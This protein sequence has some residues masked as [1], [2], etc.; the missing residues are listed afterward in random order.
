MTQ[1]LRNFVAKV[2]NSDEG[3]KKFWVFLCSG[4]SMLFV[5]SLWLAYANINIARVPGPANQLTTNDG[6][7]GTD[8]QLATDE[9]QKP[10]FFA[11]FTAGTKIIFDALKNRVAVKNDIVIN[12]QEINFVAEGLEP[13]KGSL[14]PK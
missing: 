8:R 2:R 14:L 10:G 6:R 12:K 3:T 4:I 9:I 11:I 1:S 13:V 7:Q 5:V